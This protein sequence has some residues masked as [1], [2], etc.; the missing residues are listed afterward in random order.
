MKKI[1]I[2]ILITAITLSLFG[3]GKTQSGKP[4]SLSAEEIAEK[5][6]SGSSFELPT[7]S[8]EQIST[9]DK[10]SFFY[11]FGIEPPQSVKSAIVYSP[12][13]ATIPF[14]FG[15]LILDSENGISGTA[16][17]IEKKVDRNRLVCASYTTVLTGSVRNAIILVCDTNE[18][19]AISLTNVFKEICNN[20]QQ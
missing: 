11:Y 12:V 18:E 6:I 5:I 16:S 7:L 15:I 9:D 13:I 2:Y 17:E 20:N 4:V 19:R 10:T 14:Y 1:L 3:C 8:L